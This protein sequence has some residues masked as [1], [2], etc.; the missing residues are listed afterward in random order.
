MSIRCWTNSD[1]S[2]PYFRAHPYAYAPAVA[3]APA[4]IAAPAAVVASAPAAR[5]ATL[6]TIKLNPGH[7]TAYRVD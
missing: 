6:T 5:E 1:H 7:A 2:T 4:P 3:A